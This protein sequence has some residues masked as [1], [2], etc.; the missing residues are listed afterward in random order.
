MHYGRG[1]ALINASHT[2]RRRMG[3]I[4][5][6]AVLATLF[7]V[8]WIFLD[9]VTVHRLNKAVAEAD[10]TDP[11]WRRADLWAARAPVPDA[12][13]SALLV[14][15]VLDELPAHWMAESAENG[16]PASRRLAKLHNRLSQLDP[17][18]RLSDPD[19]QRL[20]EDLDALKSARGVALE[21][22]RMPK[23]R[24]SIP[25]GY[26]Y[27]HE[28]TDHAQKLRQLL[29]LLQ[30]DAIDRIQRNDID[31]AL[32][33]CCAI[34]N[35]GRSIGDEPILISQLVRSA[36]DSVAL[37]TVQRALAQGIASDRALTSVQ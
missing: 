24:Y 4:G 6:T 35:A 21:L 12:E 27:L 26:L 20:H 17:S 18:R 31:G 37:F 30:L 25:S 32:E 5:T 2:R 28:P 36:A 14:Q 33:V 16:T 11:G 1:S 23:G 13:N 15:R 3:C 10:R 29:R 34:S 7:G 8:P 19:G 22:A 9:R